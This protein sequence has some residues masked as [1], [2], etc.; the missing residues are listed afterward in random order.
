VN[1]G[2][3]IASPQMRDPNFAGTVV[4]LCHHNSDGA[5]GVVI[6]RQTNL[7][8]R[9][10]LEQLD[11]EAGP[12]ADV[13]VLWGGPVEQGAGFVVFPGAVEDDTGWNLPGPLAVSPSRRQLED[14]LGDGGP[15]FLCLGYAGW[16]PGQ[17]DSE[18][19]TGSWLYIEIDTNLVL[20]APIPQRYDRALE[21]LGLTADQIWMVPV[22]E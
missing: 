4:L 18:I 2:L 14:V 9:E 13:Q 16:G 10:I 19:E 15:F 1:A 12:G 7:T 3:L 5:L 17:L 11:V 21:K 6:N 20:D 8:L 22:N